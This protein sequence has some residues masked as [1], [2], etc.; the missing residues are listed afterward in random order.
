MPEWRLRYLARDELHT[1]QIALITSPYLRH[2]TARLV[3]ENMNKDVVLHMISGA[4]LSLEEVRIVNCTVLTTRDIDPSEDIRRVRLQNIYD[5]TPQKRKAKLTLFS[6]H[7]KIAIEK[8]ELE[9]WFDAAD[10][11]TLQRLELRSGVEDA[12][13]WTSTLQVKTVPHLR[14]LLLGFKFDTSREEHDAATEWLRSL[15]TKLQ[16]LEICG[17]ISP[18]IIDVA[19]KPHGSTLRR[20]PLIPEAHSSLFSPKFMPRDLEKLNSSCPLLEELGIPIKRGIAVG[21]PFH[22]AQNYAALSHFPKFTHLHLILDN[23]RWGEI[24]D[25]W[26]KEHFN[27]EDD[28]EGSEFWG[29][30]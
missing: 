12:D 19:V 5:Q 11:S 21:K 25:I 13:I 30:R 29:A 6:I 15:L 9:Q 2:I 17:N 27:S 14:E 20:L 3:P 16:T 22:E 4:N 8:P 18:N 7:D 23:A 26:I 28:L 1:F 10:M 24:S